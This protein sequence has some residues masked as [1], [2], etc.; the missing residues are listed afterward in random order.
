ML[1]AALIESVDWWFDHE[2]IT[3]AE[4]DSAFYLMAG[5]MIRNGARPDGN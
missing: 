2:S 1:A 4:I 3:P 5:T